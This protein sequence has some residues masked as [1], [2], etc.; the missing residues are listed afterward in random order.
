MTTVSVVIPSYNSARHL[1]QALT[2]VQA[3]RRPV[4]EILV[5]DDGSEDGSPT[6]AASLGTTCL[7]TGQN[8]GPSRARNVGIH[9]ARGDVIAF[10]DA[11]DWWDPG[12]TEAVIG[13]LDRFPEAGVAFARIRRCGSWT[14]E[15]DRFIPE[16]QPLDVFWISLRDNIVPQMAVA[17]RR[18]VLLA[19]G[20]YNESMRFAEDYDLWL[21]LARRGVRFVCT[22]DVTANYRGHEEQASEQRL[23]LV[24]GA[25]DSRARLL[26][27]IEAEDQATAERVAEVMRASWS[28]LISEAWRSRDAAFFALAL[29]LGALVP[30]TEPA[31]RRWRRARTLWPA[32]LAAA[33][34]WDRIPPAAQRALR[35]PLRGLLRLS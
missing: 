18:D 15:S 9:S 34:L 27:T 21:R 30:G 26:R 10:L 35:A 32:W 12:H 20:G 29:E 4:D 13:L 5:V 23:K 33:R 31:Q 3:Q 17:V 2:S 6:L 25:Y 7:F 22:H 11:D 19:A 16:Q 14:G 8:G 28:R 1:A 24:R